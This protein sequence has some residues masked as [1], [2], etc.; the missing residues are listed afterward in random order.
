ACGVTHLLTKPS[1][2]EV[3]LQTVDTA[4]GLGSPPPSPPPQEEFDREHLRWL[5][6]KLSQSANALRGAN[7]RLN[8]LVEICLALASER[9]P[10]T[11][12]QNVCRAAREL[13]GSQY[14]AVGVEN[15]ERPGQKGTV[16]LPQGDSPLFSRPLE[17]GEG[18]RYF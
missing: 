8:A 1:E 11:L 3:V 2:P 5:T 9:D 17:E 15:G 14:A 18:L 4:L 13:I 10:G 6:D 7:L 12:L 16:P